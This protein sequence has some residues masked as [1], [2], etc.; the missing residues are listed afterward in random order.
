MNSRYTNLFRVFF[1][2]VDLCA[3]NI[4]QLLI[5]INYPAAA[6]FSRTQKPLARQLSKIDPTHHYHLFSYKILYY[7]DLQN[8]KLV[9]ENNLSFSFV[10]V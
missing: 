1:L 3:L 9:R 8:N 7:Q 2:F 10:L 5:F 6:P 4:V